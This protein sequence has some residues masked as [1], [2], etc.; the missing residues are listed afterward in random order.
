MSQRTR[1]DGD[2][3]DLLLAQ[4]AAEA[5]LHRAQ[6]P[7]ADA[8]PRLGLDVAVRVDAAGGLRAAEHSGDVVV[9]LAEVAPEVAPDLLVVG[10]LAQCMQ[11]ELSGC[12][13][14]PLQAS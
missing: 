3:V 9:H 10:R 11:P 13:P 8:D 14:P 2:G 5:V 12:E 6:E 1:A 4:Q 7:D